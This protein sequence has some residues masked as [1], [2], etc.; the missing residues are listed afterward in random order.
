[1][2]IRV[3][4]FGQLREIVGAPEESADVSE[5]A[6]LEDLFE[7]YGRRFPKFGEFR[8]AAAIPL[9]QILEDCHFGNVSAVL[10]GTLPQ[11][12]FS[13]DLSDA[14]TLPMRQPS[15]TK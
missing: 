10:R 8:E 3:L 2:R 13:E 5:G 12:S 7:R 14:V 11:E 4:F 6:K 1:M 15:S 9:K